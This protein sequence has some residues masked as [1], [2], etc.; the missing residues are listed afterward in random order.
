MGRFA[1]GFSVEQ[2]SQQL[3]AS[4]ALALN[5]YSGRQSVDPL[6]QIDDLAHRPAGPEHEFSLPLFGDLGV[7]R[8]DLTAQFLAL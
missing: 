8:D 2:T 4:T 7:E 3:F 6:R 1:A 5:K